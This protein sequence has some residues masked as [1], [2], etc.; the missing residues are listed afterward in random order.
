MNRLYNLLTVM[1]VTVGAFFAGQEALAKV[2]TGTG[3]EDTL[4]G[5]DRIDR[6]TGLA[7][8]DNLKGR[9]GATA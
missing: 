3:G 6:L 8:E 1:V 5:T 7:G 9:A 2:L 4:I